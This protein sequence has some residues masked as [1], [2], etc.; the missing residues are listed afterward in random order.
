MRE[1]IKNRQSLI[2]LIGEL[3]A[4]L[5]MLTNRP[6]AAKRVGALLDRAVKELRNLEADDCLPGLVK[7]S[8]ARNKL[9]VDRTVV[10]NPTIQYTIT[11]PCCKTGSTIPELVQFLRAEI[12]Q[13]SEPCTM[14]VLALGMDSY[15][16]DARA[17]PGYGRNATG[18]DKY[19]GY[20]GRCT[21]DVGDDTVRLRAI[22]F[23]DSSEL[24][25][26]T[27]PCPCYDKVM[28]LLFLEPARHAAVV[29][30]TQRAAACAEATTPN[31]EE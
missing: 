31:T 16:I 17:L 29:T 25:D 18:Y 21:Y 27:V 6:K 12:R 2:N 22:P 26:L 30:A 24:L 19:Q 5:T 11:A 23:K 4:D 3:S 15:M 7:L 20:E 13:D 28:E 8:E 9:F 10:E 14:L 1:N